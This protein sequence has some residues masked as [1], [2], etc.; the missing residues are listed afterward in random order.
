MSF[1]LERLSSDLRYAKCRKL[2]RICKFAASLFVTS[3]T[4]LEPWSVFEAAGRPCDVKVYNSRLNFAVELSCV[5]KE[6]YKISNSS[7]DS[8][9]I[10]FIGSCYAASYEH[11]EGAGERH[12]H[13]S[14]LHYLNWNKVLSLAWSASQWVLIVND[15]LIVACF[16]SRSDDHGTQSFRESLTYTQIVG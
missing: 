11:M 13:T 7:S 3:T 16:T 2:Q 4:D 1:E 6:H 5:E 10:N 15:Y 12:V 14:G 9:V 8:K